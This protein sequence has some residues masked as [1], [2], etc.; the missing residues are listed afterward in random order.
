MTAHNEAARGYSFDLSKT[1]PPT[2]VVYP[3]E[4]EA[5]VGAIV[6][7]DGRASTDPQNY[8]LTYQWSFTQVP[9]GSQV[10][11][12]GFTDLE[13]DS[14]VVTF[15]PDVTGHYQISLVV[16]NGYL[17]STPALAEI[18]VRF[19]LVAN[20]KGLIPDASF[21]WRYLSDF[22]TRVENRGKFEVFWSSAIQLLGT[23]LLNL[24]QYDYNKSI[25][26]IQNLMQRRWQ[27]YSP[28]LD[29]STAVIRFVLADDQAGLGAV[30]S[31]V[32]P[33][34]G[35]PREVQ[36]D[37]ANLV[38][39]PADQGNFATTSYG[40][41]C[42][43]RVLT[44][45]GRS[46][47]MA[48]SGTTYRAVGFGQ[49]GVTAHPG[50]LV[51]TFRGSGFN[52]DHAGLT[53]RI[54]GTSAVAGD[55]V[56]NTVL[57]SYSVLL[58]GFVGPNPYLVELSYSVLTTAPDNVFYTDLLEVVPTKQIGQQWRFSATMIVDS[59][60]E[61][62]GVSP[63]DVIEVQ[64]QRTDNNKFGVL[65]VQVVSVDRNRVGFVFNL[66]DLIPG[67]AAGGL[68]SAA[69]TSLADALQVPTVQITPAGRLVYSG[70][71]AAIATLLD[72][73]KFRRQYYE[74][75]L[76]PATPIN[77]GFFSVTL[78]PLRIL[79]N[80]MMALPTQIMSIPVLQE[81]IKI[82][83][84]TTINGQLTQV[85]VSGE[86]VPLDHK[87][88]LLV[89][90]LDYILD[91]A[92]SI[93]G[94]CSLQLGSEIIRIPYGDL[95]D[96]S[97][98][99]GD[100]LT[101]AYGAEF[102]IFDILQV[103][104]AETIRVT[105]APNVDL[106]GVSFKLTRKVAGKFLR[107]ISGVFTPKNPVPQRLWAEVSYFDNNDAVEG[108]FGVLVGLM[109]E[110]F[111]N[112]QGTTEYKSAIAGLMYAMSTGPSTVAN[113]ELAGQILL[114]LPFA[115][116][117]GVITEINQIYRRDLNGAPVYG[118]I[119]IDGRDQTGKPTGITNI[120]FFPYGKQILRNL[121]WISAVPEYS[122]IAINPDTGK[123]YVVGDTVKQFA[124]LSKGAKIEEYLD[125]PEWFTTLVDQGLFTVLEKYHAF[126]F[127]A[128]SDVISPG[129]LDLCAQ[130]FKVAK[131]SHVR[132]ITSLEQTLPEYVDFTDAI[133][134][135]YGTPPV[136]FDTPA[137]CLPM[138]VKFDPDMGG[139]S[140]FTFGGRIYLEYLSGNDLVT[141]RGATQVSSDAGGFID[142]RPA[143]D[144]SHDTPYIRAGDVLEIQDSDNAGRYLITSVMD[145]KTLQVA[146]PV[147][148][149]G[150]GT[151]SEANSQAF[152]V[153]RPV[154]NP[155][156]VTPGFSVTHGSATVHVPTG[157]FSA[158]IGVGQVVI[159]YDPSNPTWVSLP[160]TVK[161]YNPI[162]QIVTLDSAPSEPSG[163]YH[164]VFVRE[165]VTTAY[166]LHSPDQWPLVV[167]QVDN[168][169]WIAV[170]GA[171]SDLFQL[172]LVHTGDQL[173]LNHPSSPVYTILGVDRSGLRLYVTPTPAG[174][175][176]SV[177][178]A[179]Q[180]PGCPDTMISI[181][182]LDRF[183]ED[184]L[185]LVLIS[186]AADL[187]TTEGSSV[188][189][190]VSG[191]VFDDDTTDP[192]IGPDPGHIA[193]TGLFVLPGDVLEILSGA[194]AGLHEIVG[195]SGSTQLVLL[196]PLTEN[197]AAPGIAYRLHR[198]RPL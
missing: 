21:I 72:T 56:I 130:Y 13:D 117:A 122:G 70:Q 10:E 39:V 188:V 35:Q 71:A 171:S 163:S 24:Y 69:Q 194:D 9:I 173:T 129:D 61:A 15:A 161:A 58:D 181:D 143:Y 113:M 107:L 149:Y 14:S 197:H 112:Q 128:N 79:R 31:L 162:T 37:Y 47:T 43:G 89:E 111:E 5:V 68:S 27:L 38:A 123:E 187:T 182:I 36:L 93:Y 133:E 166:L 134:F 55:Y 147:R 169:P 90:N 7:L 59:N 103:V 124:L 77:L 190:T 76:T 174:S 42:V 28:A 106:V 136:M 88:Y 186:S 87:P 85:T 40:K 26:D 12:D 33:H 19:I 44:T 17:D 65:Q 115:E 92:S 198:K 105:P 110:Q 148:P 192:W 11:S 54:N 165:G 137:F 23:E 74:T 53:L 172:G 150:A 48:R 175:Y 46:Y 135:S 114:G 145:D 127:T 176:A 99:P 16:N 6:K 18:D 132:L 63:G 25:R 168:N 125:S 101:I 82:P 52:Q 29:L 78:T 4:Y 83:N 75:L 118:R 3:L 34:T 160:Y 96:R 32:D 184:H 151:F 49:D 8:D 193:G 41:V 60:M 84:T 178:A 144:E 159:F 139:G 91:D 57:N 177:D 183:P 2:A 119:L 120:Y 164:A 104:D 142:A 191:V 100:T 167:N 73:V 180:R 102:P 81:H 155:Y 30:T 195:G 51:N 45:G 138:A 80:R 141:S 179:I 154:Q 98:K 66:E 126:R 64:V 67:V 121:E 1:H 50:D 97:I 22:W 189:S 108:N 109:R 95:V 94:V 158:S 153:Y 170:Q 20:H 196:D 86:L 152:V 62:Q 146:V 131:P 156:W 185:D 116:S 140:F 157:G